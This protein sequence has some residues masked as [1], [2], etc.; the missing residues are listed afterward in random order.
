MEF[1]FYI[2]FNIRLKS[3]LPL[4]L[5]VVGSDGHL[6]EVSILLVMAFW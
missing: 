6:A 2:K 4:V 5:S 3:M 1:L